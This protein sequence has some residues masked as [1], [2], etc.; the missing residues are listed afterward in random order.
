MTIAKDF[1]FQ[2]KNFYLYH[3]LELLNN[4]FTFNVSQNKSEILLLN[5]P[6]LNVKS[7][8]NSIQ[9][10]VIDYWNLSSHFIPELMD[11]YSG[12]PI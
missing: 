9:L 2:S 4:F 5:H 6:L 3:I 12:F 10:L 8:N 1:N 7:I 11:L